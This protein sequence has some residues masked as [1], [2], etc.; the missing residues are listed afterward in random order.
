M[1]P[2]CPLNAVIIDFG[3]AKVIRSP[4][5]QVP[6]GSLPDLNNLGISYH[7]AAPEAFDRLYANLRIN[8]SNGRSV[9][10]EGKP[11]DVYSFG[12]TC[13]EMLER[14]VPFQK[15]SNKEVE[16]KVKSGMRPAISECYRDFS[17]LPDGNRH[18]QVLVK[19][20][21][22]C[23]KQNPKDRPTFEELKR[24]LRPFWLGPVQ[25]E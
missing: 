22:Q 10:E 20:I 4:N 12:M 25:P 24:K 19:C 7:Y 11:V 6:A 17:Q 8:I 2:D 1:H 9:K 15:L 5:E 18:Y 14:R 13:W 3:L 21:R 16:T 23:W